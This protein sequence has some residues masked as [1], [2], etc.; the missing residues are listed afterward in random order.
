MQSNSVRALFSVRTLFAASAAAAFLALAPAG[1]AAPFTATVFATGAD[2]SGTAPDSITVGGGHVFVEYGN[3]SKSSAPLGKGGASTIAEYDLSGNLTDSFS[4]LGS[5]DGVRYNP[6]TNQLWVLQNQDG[7]SALTTIDPATDTKTK[8]TYANPSTG[9]GFDDVAFVGGKSYFS[10]TNPANAGDPI[11]YS[12]TLGAGTVNLTSAVL[13]FGD[14]GTTDTGGNSVVSD[15]D[16]LGVTPDGS[17]LLTSG[18]DGSLTTVSHAGGVNQSVTS[19]SLQDAN[20]NGL[21]GLDD[22]VF[23]G[24]A[25]QD[26]L[27]ADTKNNTI[28][29]V[30]GPFQVGTAYSSIGALNSVDS[31]NLT[32]GTVTSISDGLFAANASPHGLGF[33]PA[34]VPE[35]STTVSFGLLLA[36]GLGGLV[37]AKKKSAKA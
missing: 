32:T 13:S 23:A 4:V 2:V 9:R 3:G 5:A 20:G 1:Q 17:L 11:I 29:R 30:A 31:V 12:A 27:V 19:V 8:F 25:V 6:Y 24:A 18:D 22:T 7:N 33:I 34:A 21:S 35:A 15:P 26:L 36:L 10:Y 28:Y 14:A 37:M 16:S